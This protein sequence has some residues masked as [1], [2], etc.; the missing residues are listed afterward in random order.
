MAVSHGLF[1]DLTQPLQMR[2]GV[3]GLYDYLQILASN[4]ARSKKGE[5]LNEA[6]YDFFVKQRFHAYEVFHRLLD[7]LDLLQEYVDT[8]TD[9]YS[10]EQHHI[11][12]MGIERRAGMA[13][14]GA[15]QY[16]GM[17]LDG[18]GRTVPYILTDDHKTERDVDSFYRVIKRSSTKAVYAPLKALFQELTQLDTWWHLAFMFET[19]LRQRIIHY[20]DLIAFQ[21]S[22]PQDKPWKVNAYLTR[23]V[24]P[25]QNQHI[26][27]LE[28][29]PKILAEMCEW[30]DNFYNLSLDIV[31]KRA[32]SIGLQVKEAPLYIT[33]LPIYRTGNFQ[34]Y[35]EN[36]LYFPHCEGS[37]QQ[38]LGKR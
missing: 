14:D 16:L 28:L 3:L 18:I 26:N 6:E 22:K 27:I 4:E 11:S 8:M 20:P 34:A 19:G 21:G 29:L 15:L 7:S 25:G 17:L 30:L 1:Q 38:K 24:S 12:F 36:Y 23:A 32:N 31:L 5:K 35:R 9:S 10:T 2:F 33:Y 37:S 13:A